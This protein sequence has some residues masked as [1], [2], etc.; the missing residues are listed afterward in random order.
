MSL[1]SVV[2][3]SPHF[4]TA[5]SL[6]DTR[7]CCLIYGV[8]GRWQHRGM[9]DVLSSSTFRGP[10]HCHTRDSSDE[11]Q[12]HNGGHVSQLPKFNPFLDWG[13]SAATLLKIPFFLY[14]T[15]LP[16]KW[17]KK[18][19]D[20]RTIGESGPLYSFARVGKEL[21]TSLWSAAITLFEKWSCSPTVFLLVPVECVPICVH[22]VDRWLLIMHVF[23]HF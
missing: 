7:G 6:C 5:G 19:E 22:T 1:H 4:L 11:Q 20:G 8:L 15:P 9:N 14:T 10:S 3:F 13:G 16:H 23:I 21:K 17:S 18:A 12:Q 2:V